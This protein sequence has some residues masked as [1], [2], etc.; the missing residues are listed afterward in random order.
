MTARRTALALAVALLAVL[1]VLPPVAGAAGA[2][3]QLEVGKLNPA[4]VEAL[5][6]P[7]VALGLGRL[8]SPVEVSVSSAATARAASAAL[9]SSFSLVADGRVTS[10]VKDQKSYNT[11]WAFANTAALESKIL[12][13][14]GQALDLSEDNLVGRSGYWQSRYDR[15][16]GGGWDFMAVAYYAR[17]AGPVDEA[18]DRYDGK[19]RSAPVVRH[20]EGAVMIPGRSSDLDNDLIKQLVVAN[21]ALSVGMY[22]DLAYLDAGTDSYYVPYQPDYE[23]HGVA[24]VGWDDAYARENFAATD[25]RPTVDGAFL[26]RNS[27]GPGFGT[28]GYFWVSYAD[29]G[30]A[31]DFGFGTYGG[32]TSYS[33]V[34]GVRDYSRNYGYDKLGVTDRIGYKDG[35]PIWA[36]NGF[37]SVS[38]RPI[39]AVGFYTL[40]SGTPYE[41]WAGRSRATLTR[42]A[43]GSSTLPGYITVKLATP[44]KVAKGARFVVAIKLTSPDKRLPL[45]IERRKVVNYG[46]GYSMVFAPA[47]A[48]A[49]Q[50][51]VG[52]TRSRMRDLTSTIPSANVCLKAFAR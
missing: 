17:W 28:D 9:P 20:V 11:C 15:Y 44:L 31:R 41:V 19:P 7:M 36:A 32:C 13:T 18:A 6:D 39:T 5:H 30:F 21:G 8:P 33:A 29:K 22:M 16:D 2:D 40:S 26:V 1:A 25:D 46:Y 23:N 43:S 35:S 37:T 42:R 45:A 10:P 38:I 52:A 4:F 3:P 49:G 24:I 51:Y 34:A 12:S 48:G 47:T 27:W 50:S 14:E